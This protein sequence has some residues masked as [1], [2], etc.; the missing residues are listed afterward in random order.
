[1]RV[2]FA[3]LLVNVLAVG[4][5]SSSY[6]SGPGTT[7]ANFL[8]IGVGARAS[9][10]GEAF[11]ALID[12]GT[13]IYWNPAGL[14][15]L[16]NR[17]LL[18]MY[19]ISYQDINQGYLSLASPL[20]R[21]TIGVG[22]NYVQIGGIEGTDEQGNFTGDFSASDFQASLAY[23]R[24]ISPRLRF[25]LSAGI[26]Q[27]AIKEDKTTT[28]ISNIGFL[29]KTG[30]FFSFGIA[31]QNIGSKLDYDP[32]PVIY[33]TG[34]AIELENF[35]ITVDAVKPMDDDFYYCS[36][37][38]WKLKELLDLRFGYKA[39]QDLGSGMTFGIGLNIK[40]IGFDYAYVSYGDLGYMQRVSSSF[41]F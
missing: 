13:S 28:F 9:A 26:L 1:M 3:I 34:A 15:K 17:E 25:G 16:V 29:L 27:D 38:E 41:R 21:G 22:I 4:L 24:C 10:M 32:L 8:K 7:G 11:T 33:R 23:A 39:K 2:K 31:V 35:N 12:D 30:R 5:T 6:A 37:I 18:V 36:G 20:A 19:N 40:K 14:T